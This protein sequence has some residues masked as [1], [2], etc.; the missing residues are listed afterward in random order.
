MTR[1]K[2]KSFYQLPLLEFS[3][4]CGQLLYGG[5]RGPTLEDMQVGALHGAAS[6]CSFLIWETQLAGYLLAI[7]L[8]SCSPY[9]THG[10]WASWISSWEACSKPTTFCKVHGSSHILALLDGGEHASLLLPT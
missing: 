8:N 3:P 9:N 4:D 10:K 1:G 2:T 7:P 6:L 5:I